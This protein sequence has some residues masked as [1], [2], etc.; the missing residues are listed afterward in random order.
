MS[1]IDPLLAKAVSETL[2][3]KTDNLDAATLS[4]LNQA[5][6]QALHDAQGQ[7]RGRWIPGGVAAAAAML[8][9][10]ISTGHRTPPPAQ[11]LLSQP[12]PELTILSSDES[13]EMLQELEFFVWLDEELSDGEPG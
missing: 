5:R 2:Q 11:P 13:L 8:A 12:L 3:E 4:R 1:D 10:L 7:R 6:Q 9:L